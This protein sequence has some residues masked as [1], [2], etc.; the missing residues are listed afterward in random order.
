[1]VKS[2]STMSHTQYTANIVQS[3]EITAH[4][5]LLL[6]LCLISTFT[7]L[8]VVVQRLSIP[9]NTLQ[10]IS[11]DDFYKPDD[12]TNSVKALKETTRTILSYLLT[13]L[14]QNFNTSGKCGK[15]QQL[16]SKHVKQIFNFLYVT[17]WLQNNGVA[18]MNRVSPHHRMNRRAIAMM[19]VRPSGTG[20]HCDHTVQIS[21]DLSLWL[22][23]PMFWVH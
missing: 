5:D 1:M 6:V 11:G 21:T 4:C 18:H 19:F 8:V 10:V 20:M 16:N 12:Q 17:G 23:S 3:V 14:I 2:S 7:Y 15:S 13:C 9:L 22:D